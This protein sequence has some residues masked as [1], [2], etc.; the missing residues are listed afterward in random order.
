M[1]TVALKAWNWVENKTETSLKH[2]PTERIVSTFLSCLAL[3]TFIF[4]YV[5]TFWTLPLLPFGPYGQNWQIVH[6]QTSILLTSCLTL[7][8]AF[9][10][11]CTQCPKWLNFHIPI[12]DIGSLFRRHI[13]RPEHLIGRH[14]YLPANWRSFI[15]WSPDQSVSQCYAIDCGRSFYCALFCVFMTRVSQCP[16]SLRA[17]HPLCHRYINCTDFA[18]FWAALFSSHVCHARIVHMH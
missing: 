3:L 15:R 5:F 8:C 14:W 1:R 13:R 2:D 4:P 9:C 12:W 16:I 6:I 7:F 18:V 17:E 11:S 10:V